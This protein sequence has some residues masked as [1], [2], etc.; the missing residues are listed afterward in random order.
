ML[1]PLR[2]Y[3]AYMSAWRGD[4]R[5]EYLVYKDEHGVPAQPQ[6]PARP[7]SLSPTG[8][9]EDTVCAGPCPEVG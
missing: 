4:F 9:V 5:L 1:N 3:R 7:P 6:T 8:L 2:A